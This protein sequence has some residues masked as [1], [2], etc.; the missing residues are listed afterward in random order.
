MRERELRVG[1]FLR[2][3][4]HSHVN[5]PPARK[6][7]IDNPLVLASTGGIVGEFSGSGMQG[8]PLAPLFF[9]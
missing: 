5:I 1:V 6:M 3:F 9:S 7:N 8:V 4:C 2:T